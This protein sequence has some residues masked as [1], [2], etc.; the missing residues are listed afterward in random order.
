MQS[1]ATTVETEAGAFRGRR[2]AVSARADP[3]LVVTI[4]CLNEPDL[5]GSL[6]SLRA[7]E[8][9][10]CA[11]EVMVVMVVSNSPAGCE[12][13]IRANNERAPGSSIYFEHPLD[14]PLA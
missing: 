3:G 12:E 2:R 1:T 4:P 11:V 10:E 9:P 13:T 8:P 5:I 7:C 14:G 6:Q